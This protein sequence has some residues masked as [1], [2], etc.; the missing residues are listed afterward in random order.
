[1]STMRE[2]IR[3]A[4]PMWRAGWVAALVALV[5]VA[6][7]AIEATRL[8]TGS[9]ESAPAQTHGIDVTTVTATS[10]SAGSISVEEYRGPHG[11]NQTPKQISALDYEIRPHGP[12]QMPKRWDTTTSSND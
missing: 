12:N 4:H 5:L 10:D 7:I 8:E 11:P 3:P 6:A 2:T 9:I 1:M